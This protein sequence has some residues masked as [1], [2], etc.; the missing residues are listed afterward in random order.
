MRNIRL[1]PIAA[2]A[3]A[4]LLMVQCRVVENTVVMEDVDVRS[5]TDTA[6]VKYINDDTTT[7][8]N[9][10]VTLH[11]NRLYDSKEIALE[12][13]TMT[14]DSLRHTEQVVMPAV[15]DWPSEIATTTDIEIP[16]REDVRF[17]CNGEYVVRITPRKEVVGVEAAGI[18]FQSKR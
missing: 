6:T 1:H 13:S 7:L 8:R 17:R 16:Y 10:S 9:L 3:I 14:P 11:V 12:I 18:N 2:A 15:A 4:I 5:W